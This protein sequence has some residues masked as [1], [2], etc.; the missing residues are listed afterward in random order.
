MKGEVVLAVAR[1]V[2]NGVRLRKSENPR[3]VG[4][5]SHVA[6]QVANEL[7]RCIDPILLHL[8]VAFDPG[9]RQFKISMVANGDWP[10]GNIE[11]LGEVAKFESMRHG[12][13]CVNVRRRLGHRPVLEGQR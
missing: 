11:W 5:L 13:D 2:R 12:H 1:R 8:V 9:N 7:W 6:A 10:R 4:T 3:G